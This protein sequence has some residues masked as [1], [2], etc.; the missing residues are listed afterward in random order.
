MNNKF[1]FFLLI[2][3]SVFGYT[4]YEASKQ[5][6]MFSSG[7]SATGSVLQ[8]YP[9]TAKFKYFQVDELFNLNSFKSEND[10]LIVHFWATWCGPCE[11]EFPDILEFMKLAKEKKNIKFLFVAVSDQ[12]DKIKKF[13]KKYNAEFLLTANSQYAFVED[14]NNE[15]N[16]FGTFKLPESYVFGTKNTLIRKFSGQQP[17]TQKFMLDFFRQL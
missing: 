14:R 15:L 9:E 2:I 3:G 4:I 1:I 13:L 12:S 7:V 8:V 6:E 16:K 11:V 10:I 5:A 17:W